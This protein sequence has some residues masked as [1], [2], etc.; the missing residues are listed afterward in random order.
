MAVVRIVAVTVVL[1]V[2]SAAPT[3]AQD[4]SRYRDYQLGSSVAAV[5]A[6]SGAEAAE[7]QALHERPAHI[8]R[9]EWQAPYVISRAD[10]LDRIVFGFCDEALYQ[11]TVTYDRDS[12]AGLTD[13]DVIESFSATYGTPRPA[14]R[15]PRRIAE[16]NGY[17]YSTVLAQWIGPGS[18][19]TLTRGVDTP[20]VQLVLLAT[21]AGTRARASIRES[22]RLDAQEAPGRERA[23]A[24]EEASAAEQTRRKNKSVFRP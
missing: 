14:P 21:P 15:T 5:L 18:E 3:I 16:D 8:Q 4:L 2:V 7:V 12:M 10:A 13:R 6:I 23:K 24:R 9:L 22:L 20:D 11:M 1:A 19:I 17:A